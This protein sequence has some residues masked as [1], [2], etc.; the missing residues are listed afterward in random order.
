MS[1][2]GIVEGWEGKAKGMLQILF[3]H[4]HID[5]IKISEYTVDR[6]NGAFGNLIPETSLQHLMKQLS[7]FQNE[8]HYCNMK[9][10][11]RMLGV[12]VNQT[13][14]NHSEM[15]GEGIEYSWAAAKGFYHCLPLSEKKQKQRFMSL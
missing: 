4:G 10:H 11:G 3:E 9:Y 5:P 8:K 15:T 2:Q 12:K 7:D 6:R 14:K 13:P 1:M